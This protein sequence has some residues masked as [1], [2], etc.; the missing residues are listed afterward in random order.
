MQEQAER[1]SRSQPGSQQ[2]A[3][4]GQMGRQ[5]AGEEKQAKQGPGQPARE[6]AEEGQGQQRGEEEQD[7]Q[8]LGIQGGIQQVQDVN[9]FHQ[10]AG[11]LDEE[12]Q[13]D[14]KNQYGEVGF[15]HL[16]SRQAGW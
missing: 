5:P 12:E 11:G 6:A 4:G 7:A 1:G 14:R 16:F 2:A 13:Q 3:G 8:G 10:G 15:F 9:G